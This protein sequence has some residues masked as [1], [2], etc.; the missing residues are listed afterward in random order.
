MTINR[1][2]RLTRDEFVE[3]EVSKVLPQWRGDLLGTHTLN[4]CE[5]LTI[6]DCLVRRK[7]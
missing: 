1:I 7:R 4:I 5:D 2:L 6:I 3:Q